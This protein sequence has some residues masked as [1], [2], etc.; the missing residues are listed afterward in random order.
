MVTPVW[1]AKRA[2]LAIQVAYSVILIG[3]I[4]FLVQSL[5]FD[6][7]R[8]FTP[9]P[10]NLLLALFVGMMNMFWMAF[11]FFIALG[12]PRVMASKVH[13]FFAVLRVF[14]QTWLSRYFPVK[15]AWVVHRLSLARSLSMT[16]AQ[17]G[18]STALELLTQFFGMA[19]VAA[20]FVLVR[21]E[22]VRDST[23]LMIVLP[24][25]AVL[26][27]LLG[28]SRVLKKAIG[29][30]SRVKGINPGA[31]TLPSFSLYSRLAVAQIVT[32]LLSGA[33]TALILIAVGGPETLSTLFFVIG[34]SAVANMVSV[35]AFFAPAGIGVKEGVYIFAFQGLMSLELAVVVAVL[36][37]LVSV[38]GDVLFF[39]LSQVPK[40]KRQGIH[41][42]VVAE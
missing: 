27:F 34:V 13:G 18:S 41:T 39:L 10:G 32:A 28:S 40:D 3:A 29:F 16:K 2:R 12:S 15:G 8:G 5:D 22:S 21:P 42:P 37:R 7:L 36:A 26:F 20:V 4:Y 17:M 33:S 11:V 24:L 14:G 35:L 31:F 25:L 19:A 30:L 6:L 23:S 9:E 1:R 38:I